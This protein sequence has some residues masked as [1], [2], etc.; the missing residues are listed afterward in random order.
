MPLEREA[1]VIFDDA[2][3]HLLFSVEVR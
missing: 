1:W 3:D 2:T